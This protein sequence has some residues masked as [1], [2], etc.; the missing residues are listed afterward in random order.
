MDDLRSGYNEADW[1]ETLVSVLERRYGTGHYIVLTLEDSRTNAELWTT[2]RRDSFDRLLGALQVA[3][4][5]M[6]HQLGLQEGVLKTFFDEYA[7]VIR[8]DEM[9]I[10]N[11]IDTFPRAEI[12]KY[13]VGD[14]DNLY[15]KTYLTGDSGNQNFNTLLD[16][17]NAY[18]H[19]L[20]V[21]FGINDQLSSSS[22]L[23]LPRRPGDDDDV[24]GV[25]PASTVVRTI[26]TIMRRSKPTTGCARWSTS[27][28]NARDF[29]LEVTEDIGT[30]NLDSDVVEAKM[31]EPEMREE[32]ARFV[33][34]R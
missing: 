34:G 4:H 11:N 3:V 13:V 23:Q 32:V 12:A 15:K 10:V 27:C 22:R 25:L 20:F 19:S 21:G 18:T 5:E 16:E 17:F 8:D 26:P 6:D 30:L 29:I 33:E 1:Y 14:L 24:R 9:R 31:M 28:G 7:F 2:G